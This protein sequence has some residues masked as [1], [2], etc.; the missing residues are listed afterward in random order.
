MPELGFAAWAQSPIGA[1]LAQTDEGQQTLA[2]G[3][4]DPRATLRGPGPETT[5]I[6]PPV[7]PRML[8][9]GGVVRLDPRAIG[10]MFPSPGSVDHAP[11]DLVAVE[12]TVP[13]LPWLLTPARPGA[14]NRLRPWL[15]LIVVDAATPF[16]PSARPLARV[17]P[18]TA[19]LPDLAQSWAWA[20]VQSPPNVA[21]LLCPR[22]LA[23]NHRYRACL[24][25]AFAGGRAAGMGQ[26]EPGAVDDHAPAWSVGAV[27]DVE[28]PVYHWWEFATASDGDFESLVRRL[29][30]LE[31]PG[32]AGPRLGL[33]SRDVDVA[34]PWP[35]AEALAGAERP[36]L[37]SIAGAAH[38]PAGGDDRR[39][40][41]EVMRDF[42]TRLQAELAIPADRL[43]RDSTLDD[44]VGAVAPPIYGGPH[45]GAERV[46]DGQA[47]GWIDELNLE[48][49]HR[50][51]AGLGAEYVRAHQED[52]IARA[53]EQVGEIREANRRRALTEL[54]HELSLSVHRRH[55]ATLEPGELVALAAPAIRRVRTAEATLAQEVFASPLP[56][57]A[58]SA[59]FARMLRPD[60]H[61]ARRVATTT[62]SVL[63]RALRGEIPLAHPEPLLAATVNVTAGGVLSSELTAGLA[64][65]RLV[66]ADTVR[67]VAQVNAF[68][69]VAGE[70]GAPI[71]ALEGVDRDALRGGRAAALAPS[72]EEQLAADSDA[73]SAVE[74]IVLSGEQVDGRT[75]TQIGVQIDGTQLRERLVAAL[76]P[77]DRHEQR[78][79]T[80]IALGGAVASHRL[81]PVMAYP[82]FP[83][84]MALELL[85]TTPEWFLPGLGSFPAER[86][87]L[88]AP[89]NRFIESY[90][91]G[92]NHE[93]MR[94]LLWREYP[95]DRRGSPFRRFWPRPGSDVDVPELH[96]WDP[97]ATLGEHCALRQ[98]A[99]SLLLVRG[100]VV[101]RFPDM[102]VT[103][104]PA[105]PP[106]I[107][108][109]PKMMNPNPELVR[110]PLFSFAVDETTAIY[111][112]PVDPAELAADAPGWF[113]VFQEHDYKFRFGFDVGDA[114]PLE[115]WDD[116][117]WEHLDPGGANRG[118]ADALADLRPA[119][120]NG[121]VWGAEADA[122]HVARIALQKPFRVAMQSTLLVPAPE[123]DG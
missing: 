97:G 113:I 119:A 9:P 4:F 88:L 95:T 82:T 120:A 20:H 93:L 121:L 89:N 17:R 105:L 77:G 30:P 110:V 39:P 84:P 111:A 29:G 7:K 98:D 55:V 100:E 104:V 6:A 19:E 47:P 114:G 109:G 116:L 57:T 102:V 50:F 80:R 118:F 62:S 37:L 23:G 69:A 11:N 52:L 112:L 91:A 103:A 45:A 99:F 56:N 14:R 24:V 51:A 8:G 63:L 73:L 13:E 72:L 60:G 59:S 26:S 108:A 61:V 3:E 78:L 96:V 1:S 68:P 48:P 65:Q 16:D 10:R 12:L 87:A 74:S 15:V 36:A 5:P 25:P 76:E 75:V 42:R 46:A 64:A 81:A 21:R 71:D 94:E 35:G 38:S 123:A 92:L 106:G 90:L 41:D 58:A 79:S 28:L 107:V 85:R 53:W 122:T 67:L 18:T 22:Q 43:D 44:T 31:R 40:P 117:T 115:T 54:A 66:K 86:V 33:G 70:I 27:A 101:R 83:V 49:A 32:E 34:R 2:R